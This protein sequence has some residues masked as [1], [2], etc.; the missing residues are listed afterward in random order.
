M[1]LKNTKELSVFL[2][3]K[4]KEQEYCIKRDSKKVTELVKLVAGYVEEIRFDSKNIDDGTIIHPRFNIIFGKIN[5]IAIAF[6]EINFRKQLIREYKQQL[7]LLEGY[8]TS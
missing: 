1:T 8:Y 6:E 5:E 4:I 2:S 3:K 7:Y